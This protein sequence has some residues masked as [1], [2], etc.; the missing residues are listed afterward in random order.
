LWG[1]VNQQTKACAIGLT[2]PAGR[3]HVD[4]LVQSK[5]DAAIARFDPT[6]QTA[7]SRRAAAPPATGQVDVQLGTAGLEAQRFANLAIEICDQPRAIAD[8]RDR[9]RLDRLRL[10]RQ[11]DQGEQH[12]AAQ[13]ANPCG[14]ADNHS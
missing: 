5:H 6:H 4:R 13:C 9:H 8:C 3:D 2:H 1:E 14:S 12:Q 11:T 10:S 7:T